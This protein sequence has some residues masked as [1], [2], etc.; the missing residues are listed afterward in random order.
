MDRRKICQEILAYLLENGFSEQSGI[1]QEALENALG[2][3]SSQDD[4]LVMYIDGA[5]RGNPGEAGIGIRI[6]R[7]SGEVLEE[8]SRRIGR[9][10]NNEAEYAAL[11]E[12]LRHATTYQPTRIL[13]RSDSQ[14]LTRQIVGEY[15]V[16]SAHL[17]PRYREALALLRT[18]PEWEIEHVPREDN[19]SADRLARDAVSDA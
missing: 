4:R 6:E 9:A 19:T 3:A 11:L 15:R 18:F 1:G 10:T 17:K 13:I 8:V 2:L 7:A 12:G 5:S 14:L 16:K